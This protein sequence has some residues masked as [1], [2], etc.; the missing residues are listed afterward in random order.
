MNIKTIASKF[1]FKAIG[2][3][4]LFQFFSII[5]SNRFFFASQEKLLLLFNKC[6]KS[7]KSDS[8]LIKEL[9][10]F[11]IYQFS[12]IVST[13][14]FVSIA[15]FM[16]EYLRKKSVWN[17]LICFILLVIVFI[18]SKSLD[19]GFIN[20]LLNSIANYCSDNVFEISNIIIG[21]VLVMI[22]LYFLYCFMKTSYK[23]EK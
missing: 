3:G 9:V 12:V 1:S 5:A 22:S 7:N 16:L 6:E 20:S 8:F 14:L 19:Q 11:Q 10:N 23:I 15:L 21:V 13:L 18:F 4:F 2:F 17:S